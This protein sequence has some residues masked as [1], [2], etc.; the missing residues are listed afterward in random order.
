MEQSYALDQQNELMITRK[1]LDI[2]IAQQD[3]C[4]DGCPSEMECYSEECNKFQREHFMLLAKE[5]L[6]KSS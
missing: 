2:L 6:Q 4:V 1:A 3:I 5:E